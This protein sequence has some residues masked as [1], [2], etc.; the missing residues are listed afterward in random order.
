MSKSAESIISD[1][2]SLQRF[3]EALSHAQTAEQVYAFGLN[4]IQDIFTPESAFVLLPDS[5]AEAPQPT[6]EHNAGW[7]TNLAIG[8]TLDGDCVGQ[9]LL[10]FDRPSS[11]TDTDF[12]LA[13][14]VAAQTA[15]MLAR[16]RERERMKEVARRKDESMAIA[17]HELR[18]P[19]TAIIGATFL[20]RSEKEKGKA[21]EMI[22]RNARAQK[23]LIEDLLNLSQVD[24]GRLELR[25]NALD[26]VPIIAQV[27]DDIRP[28]ASAHGVFVDAQL[29]GA[30]MVRGDARRL[31]QIFWNLLSNSLRF[32]SVDGKINV[33]AETVDGIAMVRVSDDGCGI[34][35]DRLPFIFDRF[36]QAHEPRTQHYDG[37][38]LGLAIVKEFVTMHGGSISAESAG[39]GQGAA[40]TIQFP[41]AS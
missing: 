38:G 9:F 11:F 23:Q 28:S 39:S 31:W 1:V 26:L 32:S 37:L 18:S 15:Q 41:L 36:E 7:V 6:A 29:P 8:I 3:V 19:L 10:H 4:A 35:P 14:L 22:D 13:D 25:L 21:I 40:F 5:G 27:V 33:T 2:R 17:V 30:I 34:S 20:L 16:I 24:T 12:A